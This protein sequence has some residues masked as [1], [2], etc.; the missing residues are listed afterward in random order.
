MGGAPRQRQDG[1]NDQQRD[2]NADDAPLE[3]SNELLMIVQPGSEPREGGVDPV[4]TRLG[5]A[6]RDAV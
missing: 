6:Y 4:R 5:G 2:V 1:R 3:A